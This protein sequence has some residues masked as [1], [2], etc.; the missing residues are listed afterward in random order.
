MGPPLDRRSAARTTRPTART[1]QRLTGTARSRGK[2][3]TGGIVFTEL[4]V[5]HQHLGHSHPAERRRREQLRR[6]RGVGIGRA[7]RRRARSSSSACSSSLARPR[8]RPV[9]ATGSGWVQIQGDP[10]GSMQFW[11]G[12]RPDGRSASYLIV[13]RPRWALV[14]RPDRRA[15]CSGSAARAADHV[16]LMLLAE[17]TPLVAAHRWCARRAGGHGAQGLRDASRGDCRSWRRPAIAPRR[18]RP[19][20]AEHTA[21]AGRRR[22]P[23]Q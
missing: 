4:H 1:V 17:W 19:A 8:P 15:A 14:A 23:E 6:D 2:G 21:A 5:Q 13:D 11:V 10:I 18:P 22:A 3:T 9:R 7:V 12:A 16:R 20:A